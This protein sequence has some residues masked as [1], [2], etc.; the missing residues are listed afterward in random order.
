VVGAV[1][2]VLF[3]WLA[4]T[5]SRFLSNPAPNAG[6]RIDNAAA[7]WTVAIHVALGASIFR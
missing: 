1:A 3:L 4:F 7:L 6:K 2:V 5:A